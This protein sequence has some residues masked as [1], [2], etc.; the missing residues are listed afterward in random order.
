MGFSFGAPLVLM[1]GADPE[2]TPHLRVVTGFGGYGDLEQTARFLFRGE[3]DWQGER[4]TLDP[5]PY[6]RWVV[7][8]NLLTR[9]PGFEEC[10]D[11]AR[12]LLKMA[13]IAGDAQIP[14]WDG[15]MVGV[16]AELEAEVDPSRRELFRELG[17]AFGNRSPQGRTREIVPLLPRAAVAS[18][19]LYDVLPNLQGIRVPVRLIH[20]RGDRL[21]P[22]TE[23]LRVA[24]AI[25]EETQKRVYL[26]GLFTH[27]H[28]DNRGDFLGEVG[29]M[30]RFLHM[31]S[32]ILGLV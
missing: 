26:T 29:E 20:G 15:H 18:S 31:M 3:H 25:P 14:S 1:A 8:G 17:I 2:L 6:G 19:P 12:A 27:S 5:D 9:I 21:I 30:S 7:V 13:Q 10:G 23:T 16:G 28:R 24:E 4:H 11:V 32:D 22:F